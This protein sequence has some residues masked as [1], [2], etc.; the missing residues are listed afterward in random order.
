MG[1]KFL[2]PLFL[3]I[4]VI[5]IVFSVF[6]VYLR[7]YSKASSNDIDMKTVRRI[8]S[9]VNSIYSKLNKTRI[10]LLANS[11]AIVRIWTGLASMY[12]IVVFI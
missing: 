6:E 12:L 4:I 5:L 3:V 7:T 10:L 8:E 11:S 1:N 2:R 9:N